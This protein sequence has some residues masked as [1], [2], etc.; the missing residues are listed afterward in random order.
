MLQDEWHREV[1][2]KPP[3]ADESEQAKG[4]PAPGTQ[5]SNH[6]ISI[7]DDVNQETENVAN[8]AGYRYL[9]DVY[10]FWPTCS[11]RFERYTVPARKTELPQMD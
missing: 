11:R 2:L 6:D 5:S 7:N 3:C 4:T 9:T 8:R 1:N 10:A